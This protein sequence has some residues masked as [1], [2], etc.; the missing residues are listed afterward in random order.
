MSLGKAKF[1]L[2]QIPL[3][4]GDVWWRHIGKAEGWDASIGRA[5]DVKTIQDELWTIFQP[6]PK[7]AGGA[8][9]GVA[10]RAGSWTNFLNLFELAFS[11]LLAEQMGS[12]CRVLIVQHTSPI[13]EA[14]LAAV[15]FFHSSSS[16]KTRWLS[17]EGNRAMHSPS[18]ATAAERQDCLAEMYS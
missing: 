7:L 17:P 5:E 3:V 1:R 18:A 9:N 8:A 11:W 14:G 16:V 12:L 2:L 4:E 6:Q 10:L 13:L 15:G